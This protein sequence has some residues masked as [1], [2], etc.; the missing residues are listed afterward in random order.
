[1]PM[2]LGH[3]IDFVVAQVHAARGDFMQLGLPNVCAVFIDQG[4]NCTLVSAIGMSQSGREFQSP[5]AATH[6]DDFVLFAHVSARVFVIS[7]ARPFKR[8]KATAEKHSIKRHS[9]YFEGKNKDTAWDIQ[10]FY[11]WGNF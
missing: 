5:S 6:D 11:E 1:M 10:N 9:C 2:G 8:R 3:V 4:D 7:S